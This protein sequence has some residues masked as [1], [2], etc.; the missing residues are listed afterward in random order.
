VAVSCRIEPLGSEHGFRIIGDIDFPDVPG[1]RRA[2]EPELQ[3]TLVLDLA[4]VELI[5]DD[6]LGLLIW[7]VKRLRAE[8]GSLV[9]RNP[10]G[11]IRR[12]LEITGLARVIPIE[13]EDADASPP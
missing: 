6:G 4:G 10:S 9:I 7:A 13:T 3:G 1:V 11:E 5:V 12:I 8:G 2:L